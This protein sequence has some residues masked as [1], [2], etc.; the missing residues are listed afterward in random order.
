MN[1]SRCAPVVAAH[2]TLSA[3]ADEERER[4]L[5]GLTRLKQDCDPHHADKL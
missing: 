4:I 5:V 3:G 2:K 1:K